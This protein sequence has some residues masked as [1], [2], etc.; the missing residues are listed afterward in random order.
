MEGA[1]SPG[2]FRES[3]RDFKRADEEL[4]NEL[5]QRFWKGLYSPE[6]RR[7]QVAC[8]ACAQEQLR[9]HKAKVRESPILAILLIV[10]LGFAMGFVLDQWEMHERQRRRH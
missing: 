4:K 1:G 7:F 5:A 10:V 8:R 3:R 2:R 6:G 9:K